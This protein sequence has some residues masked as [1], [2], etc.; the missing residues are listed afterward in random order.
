MQ[1]LKSSPILFISLLLIVIAIPL[2]LFLLNQQQ[3]IR[4]KA[5]GNADLTVTS[6]QLTD[7][8]GNV[9][10]T[11]YPDEDI[12]VRVIIKNQ[13]SEQGLSADGVTISQIY[14][15][16]P[17]PAT[18]NS[19]SDVGINLRNGQ[20][21]AGSQN[22]YESRI[23]GSNQSAY[24]TVPYSPTSSRKLSWR[25]STANTYTARVLLNSNKAVTETNYDNNQAT[26][27][28]TVAPFST[29]AEDGGATLTKPADFDNW[30]CTV[31]TAANYP[32]VTG[33][34]QQI[35]DATANVK[36]KITNNTS[37]TI[38]VALASY[39]AYLPYVA[40]TCTKTECPDE[41]KWSW[42]QTF[43]RAKRYSLPAGKTVYLSTSVPS[44]TWQA[45]VFVNGIPFSFHPLI[46]TYSGNLRYID[47]WYHFYPSYNQ[48][49]A[50]F[51][52]PI[53]P[54]PTATP[55]MTPTSAPTPLPPTLTLGADPDI[56][57]YN[58]SSTLMWT[59]TNTT[60]CTG[61]NGW[62]GTKSLSGNQSTGPL[63]SA[64]TYTL[65]CIGPGGSITQ[66]TTV[67]VMSPPTLTP[68]PTPTRTPTPTS[69]PV[70]T[71]TPMPTATP[72]PQATQFNVTAF[73]HGIG[74]SGD[75]A[76]PNS[77]TLSNKNPVRQQRKAVLE[78]FDANNNLILTKEGILNYS[79]TA[80]NFT[81][82][83]D[84]GT[85]LTAGV[86][87]V[88][89][90]TPQYLKKLFPGFVTVTPGQ[91]LSLATVTFVT[92]DVVTDNALNILD[93]NVIVGCY[94]DFAPA[95]SCT[96]QQK[97]DADLTDDGKVNQFDYNLF[98]R[99]LTVQ[100]GE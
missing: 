48:S 47:G 99:D 1:K 10:T 2:T 88:K 63:T 68:T 61:T 25:K 43:F 19:T 97:L 53:I 56:V 37:S 20:F 31:R 39:K 34:V 42:T 12:Y 23:T 96:A 11:F 74:N 66:T 70:P 59:S 28:Y 14:S 9:R 81:G 64:K 55:T 73:M 41:W 27:T 100:N 32:G 4:Q 60:S 36:G 93:Y 7:A 69:T 71:N 95:I 17:S 85:S 13:G 22:T 84:A 21:G 52:Q 26:V 87:T 65:T 92:G 35:R 8:G 94:S 76:N 91:T 30:P 16:S 33:C 58:G 82:I 98:L 54:T 38:T 83:I 49:A 79:A 40:S 29:S 46:D 5:A 78:I 6:F 57:S 18:F 44:C 15:H 51:C 50:T 67:N 3:D 75:N 62:T 80:G 90:K 45:D 72:V 24:T 89:V 86:Y 77:F